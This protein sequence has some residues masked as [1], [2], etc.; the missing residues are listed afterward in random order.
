MPNSLGEQLF[1]SFI[2]AT[3]YHHKSG[4]IQGYFK[5]L[6]VYPDTSMPGAVYG[7]KDT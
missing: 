7:F 1:R 4:Y 5:G 6:A 3:G 2:Q